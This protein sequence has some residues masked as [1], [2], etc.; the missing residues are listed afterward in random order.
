MKAISQMTQG[1]KLQTISE[2][3]PC[4]IEREIVLRYLLAVRHNDIQQIEYFEKFGKSIRQIILN[5]HTY[6]RALLFGYTS[7]DL[8]EH[9]WLIGMLPIVEKIEVDNFNCI[10]IGKSQNGTYAVAVDW[11]TGSAGGGSHPSVFD[12]PI[13]DY[14][15]AV[16]QGIC[17][18][19]QQ[20][21]KAERYSVTDRSNYNPK[22]IS[23]LKNKLLEL[24][25]RYTQ[26]QQLTI[27]A[28]L[29]TKTLLPD[30]QAGGF[31]FYIRESL[32]NLFSP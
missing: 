24:K 10:H 5:V 22:V 31:L 32:F 4:K 19:E 29:K 13:K 28:I 3:T 30:Y 8:N 15:E 27:G 2:Y 23:K 6:E 18:L 11:C 12:E 26:P 21:S 9:G 7:K 14:K 16:R 17:Q 25:S 20:Y 1:E